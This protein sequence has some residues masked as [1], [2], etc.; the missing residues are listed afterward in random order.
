ML[1]VERLTVEGMMSRSFKENYHQ[2]GTSKKKER[3]QQV[4]KELDE[5]SK[6]EELSSYLQPLVKFY[7]WA[8]SYL[9]L[10]REVWVSSHVEHKS[11]VIF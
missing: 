3:L 4:L 6:E 7:D 11:S 9:Q 1:R 5:L 8:D 2:K 10:R